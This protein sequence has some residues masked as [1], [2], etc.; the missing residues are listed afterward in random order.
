MTAYIYPNRYIVWY[1]YDD[2]ISGNK[3]ITYDEAIDILDEDGGQELEYMDNKLKSNIDIVS[4][5]VEKDV[6]SCLYINHCLGNNRE[7]IKLI[8]KELK[9]KYVNDIC[10][11]SSEDSE[12]NKILYR[13]TILKMKNSYEYNYL[14]NR[15][16]SRELRKEY[17]WYEINTGD[18]LYF[19][20]LDEETREELD[21]VTSVTTLVCREP[22]NE[23]FDV[24]QVNEEM[25]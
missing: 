3:L 25:V 11:S 12:L 23:Y 6:T 14:T 20:E 13:V 24:E 15:L 7:L 16:M 10:N 2:V 18:N 21:N 1:N 19:K 4:Y 22:Q 17:T 9:K 8:F 5:S